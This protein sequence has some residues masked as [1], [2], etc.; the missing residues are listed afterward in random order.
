MNVPLE[1]PFPEVAI[2]SLRK[3]F[4]YPRNR[5]LELV[6][7]YKTLERLVQGETG[8]PMTPAEAVTYLRGRLEIAATAL[9][10]R[11]KKFTPH[12]TSYLNGRK[13]LTTAPPET[14][15]NL[16]DA[17]S[18]LACYPTITTVDVDAHM[19]ILKI[20]DQHIEYWRATHGAA[21]ASYLRQRTMRY[22]ELVARWPPGE[23]QFIPGADKWFRER[24][25]EQREDLWV[26]TAKT[27][28][29]SERAQL[30]RIM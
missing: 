20:I 4:P 18:V 28:F 19:P 26:R 5:K 30:Q 7:V 8:S 12:L 6:C 13:Y 2:E 15:K 9:A 22:A 1:D 23:S 27:G 14:P 3:I 11:A 10:G 25:Y 17:I 21:A 16:E 24:R 29:E